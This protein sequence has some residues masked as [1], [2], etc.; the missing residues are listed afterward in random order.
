M[1]IAQNFLKQN[2]LLFLFRKHNLDKLWYSE[3]SLDLFCD[4]WISGD[5]EYWFLI[6]FKLQPV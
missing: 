2:R 5:I 4:Y 1:T 3:E 6:K